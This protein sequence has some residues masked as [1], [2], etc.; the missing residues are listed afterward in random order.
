MIWALLLG[1]NDQWW[2]S[3]DQSIFVRL[4]TASSPRLCRQSHAKPSKSPPRMDVLWGPQ[5]SSVPQGLDPAKFTRTPLVH[6][7]TD[8]FMRSFLSFHWLVFVNLPRSCQFIPFRF[9]SS[10]AMSFHVFSSHFIL[11][12]LMSFHFSF[13]TFIWFT[14][15]LSFF[16]SLISIRCSFQSFIRS[17]QSVSRS[18]SQSVIQSFQHPFIHSFH[19][20]SSIHSFIPFISSNLIPAEFK[21][22]HFTAF[23]FVSFIPWI[24]VAYLFILSFHSF[25]LLHSFHNMFISFLSCFPS[26]H[27]IHLCLHSIYVVQFNSISSI[28]LSVRQSAGAL[29]RSCVHLSIH[30]FIRAFVHLRVCSFYFMVVFMFIP[31][32]QQQVIAVCR[33][34]VPGSTGRCFT[35]RTTIGE[36]PNPSKYFETLMFQQKRNSL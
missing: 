8:S 15:F 12:H 31:L 11:Y 23:C 9:T 18:V 1:I 5:P 17:F 10:H 34:M 20:I 21:S 4:D 7:S 32:M 16:I 22:F 3:D 13:M 2:A 6:S 24:S 26:L 14:W 30:W 25:H 36:V 28:H 27:V 33:F 29:I 19:S 35:C